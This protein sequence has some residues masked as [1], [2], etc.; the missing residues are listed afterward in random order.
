TPPLHQVP[1]CG[2]RGLRRL[3]PRPRTPSP[4]CNQSTPPDPSEPSSDAPSPASSP[5][6]RSRT[7]QGPSPD[8]RRGGRAEAGPRGIAAQQGGRRV[9]GAKAGRSG[10]A[11]L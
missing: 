6:P 2:S 5:F 1:A 8:H 11:Q 4:S 3:D 9:P 10:G 7:P